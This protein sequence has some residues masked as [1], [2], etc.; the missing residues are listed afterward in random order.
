MV[1]LPLIAMRKSVPQFDE[2]LIVGSVA[3]TG[4]AS[5]PVS[6][7]PAKVSVETGNPHT[8]E[9]LLDAMKVGVAAVD[10]PALGDSPDQHRP[11]HDVS[12]GQTH[13]GLGSEIVK[14]LSSLAE[15][16]FGAHGLETLSEQRNIA[17]SVIWAEL[18]SPDP[19]AFAF[20][21]F[22]HSRPITERQFCAIL[23]L[24]R[25]AVMAAEKRLVVARAAWIEKFWPE[26]VRF[27]RWDSKNGP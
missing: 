5:V 10:H 9:V 20:G 21:E 19:W 4:R 17:A 23:G 6:A 16:N 13:H 27:V 12:A 26:I 24:N 14:V 7:L 2:I 15:E 22:E 1:K 8:P 18:G 25:S 11:S 3:A